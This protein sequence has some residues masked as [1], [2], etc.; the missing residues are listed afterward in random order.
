[1]DYLYGVSQDVNT[2]SG[3]GWKIFSNTH[4]W[5]GR[6]AAQVMKPGILGF[7]SNFYLL[8]PPG[9]KYPNHK[10][11][12]LAWKMTYLLQGKKKISI[13]LLFFF[14][15]CGCCQSRSLSKI[16]L[17]LF[18]IYL[19]LLNIREYKGSHITCEKEI[20][21]P[22]TQWWQSIHVARGLG[23]HEDAILGYENTRTYEEFITKELSGNTSPP[24]CRVTRP[25]AWA[26]L[27]A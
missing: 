12:T 26:T 18:K 15:V 6:Q 23:S 11:K 16:S 22:F 19:K 25:G 21:F 20:L 7:I 10:M 5:L 4:D 9:F 1:M 2:V 17:F 8:I 14:A 13:I 3:K 27:S 24:P